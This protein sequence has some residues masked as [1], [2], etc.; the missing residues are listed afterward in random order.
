MGGDLLVKRHCVWQG[1]RPATRHARQCATRGN[2][3]PLGGAAP[4]G[5]TAPRLATQYRPATRH[6][7][8]VPAAWQRCTPGSEAL[9]SN[10]HCRNESPL[11][12]NRRS[13][14]QAALQAS[15]PARLPAPEPTDSSPCFTC[16]GGPICALS[17]WQVVSAWVAEVAGRSGHLRDTW[18]GL[19]EPQVG[20]RLAQVTSSLFC[21]PCRCRSCFV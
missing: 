6:G 4:F 10:A 8:N 15:N 11:G 2:G 16:N 12:T 17:R 3:A 1:P 21:R 9:L 13:P 14:A 7:L 18:A 5:T 19:V 20:Q